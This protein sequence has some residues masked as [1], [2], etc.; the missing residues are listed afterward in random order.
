MWRSLRAALLVE[1]KRGFMKRK[2][3]RCDEELSGDETADE[4][5][6]DGGHRKFRL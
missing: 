6:T 2:K 5:R 4:R 3:R 1:I